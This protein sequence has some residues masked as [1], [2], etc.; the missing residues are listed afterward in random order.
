M[1]CAIM[2]CLAWCWN[3]CSYMFMSLL[4]AHACFDFILNCIGLLWLVEL[5][6]VDVVFVFVMVPDLELCLVDI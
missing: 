2:L 5:L 6:S 4:F 1:L 3:A